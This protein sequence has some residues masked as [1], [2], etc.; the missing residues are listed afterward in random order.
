MSASKPHCFVALYA[1]DTI[2]GAQIIA[3]STDAELV[4]LAT[5]KMMQEVEH[6][7]NLLRNPALQGRR[8]ALR[9]IQDGDE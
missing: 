4:A 9:L 6:D 3:A 5:R 2:A 7:P 8:H 1:G